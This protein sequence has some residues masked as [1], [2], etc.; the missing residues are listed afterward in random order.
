M[1]RDFRLTKRTSRRTIFATIGVLAAL[2]AN[3]RAATERP[4]CVPAGLRKV[5][6]IAGGWV[7]SNGRLLRPWGDQ[8]ELPGQPFSLVVAP[9]GKTGFLLVA[10]NRFQDPWVPDATILASIDLDRRSVTR[11]VRFDKRLSVGMG[12]AYAADAKRLFLADPVGDRVIAVR[13]PTLEI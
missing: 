4:L 1:I 8:I 12:M 3:A 5:G 9:D 10:A 7:L 2:L 11:T 6:P 13:T